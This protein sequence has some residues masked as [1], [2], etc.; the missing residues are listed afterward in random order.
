[1]K[2]TKIIGIT[3]LVTAIGF[4]LTLTG[5]EE[6]IDELILKNGT[7]TLSPR[8]QG[9]QDGFPED[10]YISKVVVSDNYIRFNF[11][12]SETGSVGYGDSPAADWG[13]NLATLTNNNKKSEKVK[14]I[15]SRDQGGNVSM[16]SFPRIDSKRLK[17]EN[18]EGIVFS[19]I[20]LDSPDK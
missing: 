2:L 12:N 14:S 19:L 11:E 5:C 3:V 4:A 7:Y 9:E 6:I 16:C 17:L 15:S 8:P 10:I 20:R 13:K 18:E 1:M